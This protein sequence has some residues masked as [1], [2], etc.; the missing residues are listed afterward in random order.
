M[1]EGGFGFEHRP[2]WRMSVLQFV[3]FCKSVQG[4]EDGQEES[5]HAP[6]VV[7]VVR[8]DVHQE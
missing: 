8:P 6:E 3:V 2:S 7:A 1:V 4:E 5:D